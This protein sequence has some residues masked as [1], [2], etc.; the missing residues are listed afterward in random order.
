MKKIYIKMIKKT[1]LLIFCFFFYSI[2]F[3]QDKVLILN[4]FLHIGNGDTI[5]SA[6]IS[7]ENGIITK[8]GN[9]LT[10]SYK[11]NEWDTIINA[12]NKHIY[13][14][15]VAP[16]TTL[17][18][19][20]I[21]AVRATRDYREVGSLNPHIRSQI[22]YNVESKVMSTVLT[23]GVLICQATPRGGRVSGSSSVMKLNGWNW[24]DATIHK[25]DG[26]HVNWPVVNWKRNDP[27]KNGLTKEY[28]NEV[29]QLG[30]FF[31]LAKKYAEK[32]EK[33]D[34]IDIRLEAMKKCFSQNRRI[35]FHANEIQQILDVISFVEKYKIKYPVII[36]GYDAPIAGK[37]LKDANIPVM[38]KRVHSL[39]DMADDPIDYV[40]K[41]PSLL[42]EN[43]ILFCLENSGDM[44]AMNAR[45]IPF[46]AGTASS[47][48]LSNEE[49]IE[50]ISLSA[51]KILGIDNKYGSIEKGK[52]ATFFISDGNALDMMTNNVTNI[53]IDGK[54]VSTENFQSTLYQKYQNKYKNSQK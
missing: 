2:G 35:Y 48:G 20:E 18:L 31:C 51:C 24:Q 28:E 40:F 3:S 54:I 17:G 9:S 47:Y 25:D 38:I 5:P 46:L 49:A 22:A 29:K 41:L 10:T 4:G 52:S 44:E 15:F 33:T 42:K 7:I 53:F 30:D 16:N 6:L 23:N 34:S 12:K 43:G 39:P 32:K 13:P 45:N 37:R 50:A 11:L 21:D 1:F 27:E 14:G 26:I 36:G 8:V 19:T